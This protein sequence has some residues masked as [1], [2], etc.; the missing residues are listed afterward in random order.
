M[1]VHSRSR[2]FAALCALSLLASAG[3]AHA[4]HVLLARQVGVPDVLAAFEAADPSS[5]WV[6]VPLAAP[7]RAAAGPAVALDLTCGLYAATLNDTSVLKR[8]P[9][10]S[11]IDGSITVHGIDPDEIDYTGDLENTGIDPDEID[12]DGT[13]TNTG[14][15][16]D[17][18]DY[19]GTQTNT[20]IDPDEIDYDG[21]Q[22]N[23]GIDPD[24]IDVACTAGDD[25]TVEATSSQPPYR[26]AATDIVYV[27]ASSRGI[28]LLHN[29]SGASA[30]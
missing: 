23:T 2:S 7:A 18:I 28:Y 13:Q 21:T 12:Y 30:D 14:I 10:A 24:E 29:R 5:D 9:F 26:L 22:T 27:A 1:S 6:A 3:A 20:G 16:P 17:E 8:A 4:E 11:A 19:D 15:D 25:G